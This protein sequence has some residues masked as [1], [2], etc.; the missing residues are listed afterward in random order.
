MVDTENLDVIVISETRLTSDVYGG[1]IQLLSFLLGWT[2]GLNWGHSRVNMN[3]GS[4]LTIQGDKT[5]AS[6]SATC[7]LVCCRMKCKR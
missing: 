1:K 4:T 3:A 5:V 7:G 2:D 6:D